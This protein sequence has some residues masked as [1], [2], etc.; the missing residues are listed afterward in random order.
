MTDKD[1]SKFISLVLRHKPQTIGI[2]LDAAGWTDVAVLIQKMNEKGKK[3]DMPR[4][5]KI[6]AESDKQRYAFNADKTQIR[7]NQGHS[8]NV[9]L[10]LE[11]AN[12]PAILY[13]GTSRVFEDSIM[14]KGLIKGSRHHVHLSKDT[15]TAIKV[16][17]R[18]DKQC[19]IF[20]IDTQKMLEEGHL[21]YVS[22]NGVWL[23]DFVPAKFLK[24][25]ED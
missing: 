12:P 23:T 24:K 2:E 4:L 14:Q 7:A 13:H 3:I 19:I 11:P 21:F 6:V 10:G 16:G 1:L 15:E 5:E 18:R 25:R 17:Q 22:E 9:E 20:E 8:I